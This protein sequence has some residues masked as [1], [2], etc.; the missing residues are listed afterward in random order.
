MLSVIFSQGRIVQELGREGILPWSGF[1]ASNKPF[2]APLAGLFEH[3]VVSVIIMLAPPPGD[4][5]NFI[6]NVRIL[7]QINE[8]G[9]ALKSFAENR[10][11]PTLFLSSMS[12]LPLVWY[13]STSTGLPMTGTLQSK[14]H[15]LLWSSFYSA[16]FILSWHRLS[17]QTHPIRTSTNSSPII[18][19]ASLA[20]GSFWRVACTGR[21][22]LNCC[23]CWAVTPCTRRLL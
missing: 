11:S 14:P 22:G 3:W 1:F 15:C 7:C 17:L 21:Y 6:L 20:S 13:I 16:I 8:R 18:Y 19:I 10:S 2:S 9:L 5:Y 23:R 4:A 12:S